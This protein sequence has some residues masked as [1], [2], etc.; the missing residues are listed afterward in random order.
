LDILRAGRVFYPGLNS[1]AGIK[2]IR[3]N[4]QITAL[5]K[6]SSNGFLRTVKMDK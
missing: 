6:T 3:N 2:K 4:D 5:M 1:S